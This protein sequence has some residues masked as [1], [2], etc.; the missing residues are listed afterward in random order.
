MPINAD[1]NL[2]IS[3]SPLQGEWKVGKNYVSD[4]LKKKHDDFCQHDDF[5]HVLPFLKIF[6]NTNLLISKILRNNADFYQFLPNF[7]DFC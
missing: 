1:A 6:A 4:A 7:A 2:F 3:Q 5:C